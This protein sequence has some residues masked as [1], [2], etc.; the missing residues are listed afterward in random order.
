[1]ARARTVYEQPKGTTSRFIG[2]R[3]VG[4]L[5]EQPFSPGGVL[6]ETRHHGNSAFSFFVSPPIVLC[7]FLVDEGTRGNSRRTVL[8]PNVEEES[9][10]CL[11]RVDFPGTTSGTTP[12]YTWLG[13]LVGVYDGI[14]C[15]HLGFNEFHYFIP[16]FFSWY[17]RYHVA[18]AF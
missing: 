2:S 11:M 18:G 16:I 13:H 15:Y 3:P 5:N 14:D 4:L 8:S 1:M 6:L 10:A 17:F 9:H 12:K 7:L